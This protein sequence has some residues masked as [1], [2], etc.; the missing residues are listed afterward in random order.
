MLPLFWIA[1][2]DHDWAEADHTHLLDVQNEPQTV[3]LPDQ[4]GIPNRPLHRIP[5]SRG[6][7][8]RWTDSSNCFPT[9]TSAHLFSS[10]IREGYA[11]GRTLPE[12]FHTVL[13]GLLKDLPLFFVDGANPELKTASLPLLL[14]ELEEAEEHEA[15]LSR[16]ASHL[17]MDGYHVQV[18]ILEG[19]VNLFFEGEQG[20]DRLYR[21]GKVSG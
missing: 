10:F 1:S 5:L 6:Y 8:I 16:A 19:G 13:G 4:P 2:E 11:Q 17:E 18:P 3:Q 14:R 20:R 9:L 12:G 15:L 21:E 7:Q